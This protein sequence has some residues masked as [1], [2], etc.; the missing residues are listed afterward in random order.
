MNLFQDRTQTLEKMEKEAAETI[1]AKRC[2][3][4][5]LDNNIK[6]LADSMQGR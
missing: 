5:E 6:L 3:V 2:K 1:A 4:V